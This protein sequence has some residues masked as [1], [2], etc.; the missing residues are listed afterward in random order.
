MIISSVLVAAASIIPVMIIDTGFE[1]TPEVSHRVI[2]DQDRNNPEHGTIVTYLAVKDT[3]HN[4]VVHLCAIGTTAE[5]RTVKNCLTKALESDIKYINMS[6]NGDKIKYP[7]EY[8]LINKLT[9]KSVQIVMSSGNQ[10][11]NLDDTPMYPQSWLFPHFTIVGANDV[12]VANKGKFVVSNIS[13]VVS[14][15]GKL[16]MGTSFSSPRYLN[17]LLKKHCEAL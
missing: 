7:D 1:P 15:K 4:V 3:C 8:H 13:G 16:F 14:F 12:P 11:L 6:F 5:A 17:K 10:S 9:K 2:V